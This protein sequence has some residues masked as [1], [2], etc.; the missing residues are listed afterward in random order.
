[1]PGRERQNRHPEQRTLPIIKAAAGFAAV[2]FMLK[3]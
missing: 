1:M 2:I 3:Q